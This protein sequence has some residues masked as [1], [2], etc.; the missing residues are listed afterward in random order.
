MNEL[1]SNLNLS[2]ITKVI[3]YIANENS[4]QILQMFIHNFMSLFYR[5]IYFEFTVHGKVSFH[6]VPKK[7]TKI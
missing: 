6:N 1:K 4:N 5:I 2:N 3:S 7:T